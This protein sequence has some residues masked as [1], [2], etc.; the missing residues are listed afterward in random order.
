M[1]PVLID[2][3]KYNIIFKIGVEEMIYKTDINSFVEESG[4]TIQNISFPIEGYYIELAD[5]STSFIC[6]NIIENL[7]LELEKNEVTNSLLVIDFNKV[8]ELS[9]NF[10]KEYTKALLSTSNKIITI[11][12]S[13]G[14]SNDFSSFI[15][16]SIKEVEE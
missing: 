8:E 13:T 15:K 16:D 7:F 6:G 5:I 3:D 4:V 9:E 12:M 1:K 10:F 14:L 2:I 11:N